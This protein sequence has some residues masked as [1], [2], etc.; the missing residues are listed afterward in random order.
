M[1]LHLLKFLH[2]CRHLTKQVNSTNVHFSNA[3]TSLQSGEM[4]IK[5][6]TQVQSTG[7]DPSPYI[8]VNN[9]VIYHLIKKSQ[10]LK[11]KKMSI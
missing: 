5:N 9:R 4:Q 7:P 2:L 11:S 10:V 6:Y 1:H 3:W 8:C